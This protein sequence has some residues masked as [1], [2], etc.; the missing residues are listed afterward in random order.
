M[1]SSSCHVERMPG[2][3]FSRG[4]CL[5]VGCLLAGLLGCQKSAPPPPPAKPLTVQFVL[6]ETRM[7]TEQEEF[8]GRTAATERVELRARVSGY[9]QVVD[10]PEG[11]LVQK[12]Q[13]LFRIDDRPFRAEEKRTQAAVAQFE[14]RAKRLR[15]QEQRARSLLEKRAMSQEEY[16]AVQYE[17]TEAEAS[18][19]SALAAHETA[20]LNLE[21]TTITAPLTGRIGQRQVDVGNLV[22]QDQTLLATIIPVEKVNVLFDMD[23]RT[24]LRLRRLQQA[25]QLQ[26]TADGAIHVQVAL[27]DSD[28]FTLQGVV[29]FQDNQVDPATGT[30]RMRAVIENSDGLLSPGLFV[31]IRYPVGTARESLLIPEEC[32]ASDQG[33]PFVFVV[34][35]QEG[36]DIAAARYIETGP[37]EGGM[38]VIRDGLTLQDRVISTGL[39][40]LRRNAE[41]K[42]QPRPEPSTADKPA[43]A[44][45]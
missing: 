23:E 11:R 36:Q 17:L 29:D 41:I 3:P 40:R 33:R 32:L 42:A 43:P 5:L 44:S 35:Q 37:L 31:R 28:Q 38:R 34:Q 21:F 15:G 20:R 22:V 6:P 2:H 39:Q 18:L 27:A 8:T 9:L 10:F 12:G 1:F 25:G 16:E 45:N 7:I 14:A 24:V 13:V 26:E 4:V 19:E 30:Q